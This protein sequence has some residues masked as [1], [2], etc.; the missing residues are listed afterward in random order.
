M[1]CVTAPC[2]YHLLLWSL[3]VVIVLVALVELFVISNTKIISISLIWSAKLI[4]IAYSSCVCSSITSWRTY[5]NWVIITTLNICNFGIKQSKY[6]LGLL[7]SLLLI[8]N[9]CT[10][11]VRLILILVLW[12][13]ILI[14][15]TFLTLFSTK[16]APWVSSHCV[17]KPTWSQK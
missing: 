17:Y 1:I 5:C 12:L 4:T 8:F 11:I 13:F 2:K 9:W 14:S 7:N 6:H 15:S 10:L 16:L 3:S